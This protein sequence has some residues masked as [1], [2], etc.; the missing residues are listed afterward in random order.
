M[1]W[2][3]N[4]PQNS[5]GISSS[6]MRW[7][8]QPH[9]RWIHCALHG[10]QYSIDDS[11]STFLALNSTSWCRSVWCSEEAY[12]GRNRSSH[13]NGCDTNSKGGM[14]NSICCSSWQSS[15]SQKHTR[16]VSWYRYSSIFA[17]KSPSSPCIITTTSTIKSTSHTTK[18][19]NALQCSSSHQFSHRLQCCSPSKPRHKYPPWVW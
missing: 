3:W 16:W 12:V 1:F 2:T 18:S 6:H 13:S 10:Q 19:N 5:G 14:V 4:A 8:R 7:T 15:Q 9:Y 17:N 11:P